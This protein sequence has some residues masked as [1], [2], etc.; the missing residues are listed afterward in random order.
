MVLTTQRDLIQQ[1]DPQQKDPLQNDYDGVSAIDRPVK[2]IRSNVT[3]PAGLLRGKVVNFELLR[4]L[5]HCKVHQE[6]GLLWCHDGKVCKRS[7]FGAVCALFSLF[8]GKLC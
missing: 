8:V 7:E 6:H 2:T 3:L 5:V 1:R 4:W